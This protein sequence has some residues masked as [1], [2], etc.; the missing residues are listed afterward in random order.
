LL[1]SD[2]EC[3]DVPQRGPEEI[4]AE[5][6]IDRAD[7]AIAALAAGLVD[8]LVFDCIAIPNDSV[9]R[10]AS[11]GF[12]AAFRDAQP[13]GP[14]VITIDPNPGAVGKAV[15]AGPRYMP[16]SDRFASRRSRAK[17]NDSKV[18]P[19]SVLIAFG[20]RDSANCTEAAVAGLSGLPEKPATTVILG[21]G[22]VHAGPVNAR[23]CGLPWVRL[24]SCLEDMSDI[25]DEFHLAI[26]APG[27]SQF[28]RA[29]CGLPTVLIAQNERQRPLVEKWAQTDAAVGCSAEP[30]DLAVVVERL[31]LDPD[32]LQVMRRH[33][34]ALVD[35][36]GASRLADT[37]NRLAR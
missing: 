5:T 7:R 1:F 28:E 3:P 34:L 17:E 11:I 15:L 31:L 33:G 25:Y 36:L 14:E 35:G 4:V 18:R 8:G 37:L 26:G 27:V 19:I 23:T 13:Y 16:L 21:A 12:T 29:C 20:A 30:N 32:R 6:A 9:Q 22:A 10:A 2:P 24:R